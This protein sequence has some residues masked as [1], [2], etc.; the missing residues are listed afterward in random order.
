MSQLCILLIALSSLG[1]LS[2]LIFKGAIISPQFAFVM[3]FTPGI[4]YAFAYVDKWNLE[5]TDLT[6]ITILLGCSVFWGASI[7]FNI[8]FRKFSLKTHS[9]RIL[10]CSDSI[11][12][13]R[14]KLVLLSFLQIVTILLTYLFLYK[15]Y[16]S[17]L[18]EA[19]Y[20]Y[21]VL[22]T[23]HS[24]EFVEI[25]AFI[26]MLRRICLSIGFLS[27]Y[28]FIYEIVYKRNN[29]PKIALFCTVLS[30]INSISLG[31]RGDAVHIILAAVIQFLVLSGIKNKG[32]IL[33]V[34]SFIKIFSIFLFIFLSFSFVGE[35]LGRQMSFL[36]FGDYIA[37]YLSAELKN[38]D[39][40]VSLEHFGATF[41]D[42][43]ILSSISRILSILFQ[44][45]AIEHPL[46]N[47]F[48]FVNGYALGNVSTIFYAFLY[49]GGFCGLII[50]TIIM[51]LVCQYSFYKAV[52]SPP[53][54]IS[55][56]IIIYSYIYYTIVFSFF[57]N[58]FYEMIL[59]PVF[60]YFLLVLYVA[61]KFFYKKISIGR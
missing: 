41:Y 37:V 48:R 31:A 28:I 4:I 5:L 42:S 29:S 9:V 14:Q 35:L 8:F 6:V 23:T 17:H 19:M 59:N 32:H 30:I 2:L 49:D 1:I 47:P 60:M 10:S 52:S 43:Q 54:Q 26:K 55:L 38:L 45:P 33:N 3:C 7:F 46:V 57:S 50:F 27:S 39:S 20:S 11:H 61:K 25:P 40:F 22:S 13:L 12:N 21:R 16:G 15:N 58:K 44:D 34:R 56:S 53:E 18:S 24:P 51:S 36:E